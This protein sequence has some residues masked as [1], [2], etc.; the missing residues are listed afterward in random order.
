MTV[1]VY[2][3]SEFAGR[4]YCVAN[5]FTV[6]FYSPNGEWHSDSDHASAKEAAARVHWL[7]GGAA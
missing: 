3:Q 5:L 4:M 6:G 7:N 1:W 2:I